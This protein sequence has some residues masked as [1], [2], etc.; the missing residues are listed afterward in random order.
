MA[1]SNL[2]KYNRSLEKMIES[3]SSR[4]KNAILTLEATQNEL[5]KTRKSAI[6]SDIST[7]SLDTFDTSNT[8]ESNLKKIDQYRQRMTLLLEK[9][10]VLEKIIT[11]HKEKTQKE[12]KVTKTIQ[13]I[14]NYKTQIDLDVILKDYPEIIRESAKG[15]Q[16]ISNAV[17][18]IKLFVSINEEICQQTEMSLLLEKNAAAMKNNFKGKIDIQL[19]LEKVPLVC[20][21]VLMME[22]AVNAIL[23]NAFQAISPRGIISVSCQYLDP[24]IIIC[25]S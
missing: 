16:Q 21:P 14:E 5:H 10:D 2:T 13:K 20:I 23:D 11:T 7:L 19:D 24:N 18:D 6:A 15:I 25:I 12:E 3:K 4:L 1:E 8:I 9:Y 22:R 17:S